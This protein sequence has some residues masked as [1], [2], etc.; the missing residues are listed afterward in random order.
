MFYQGSDFLLDGCRFMRKRSFMNLNTSRFDQEAGLWDAN[1][2]RAA[3]ARSIVGL[4]QREIAGLPEPPRLMD[5][6]CGTGMCSLPLARQ[7]AT[8]VAV[9]VSPGM[10]EQ[11]KAKAA[12]L[13][14]RNVSP[15]CHD[16][17]QGSLALEPGQGFDVILTAMALH[18]VHDVPLL[19]HRF[20]SLLNRGG[21]LLLAD[22]DEE[23]GSFHT[24][25][26]GV[27]H[28]GFKR[29]WL[30]NQLWEAGFRMIRIATAHTVTKPTATGA[31]GDFPVFFMSARVEPTDL[32]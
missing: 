25:P 12:G 13:G 21:V 1:P 18:H 30:I 14:L 6:G 29:E 27:E 8:V 31:V 5:Y 7:C 10:L 26:T 20:R 15:L 22:L 11:L 9:D 3:L 2:V 17:T 28:H 4:A 32:R 24:N 16:L 23:N 19:L